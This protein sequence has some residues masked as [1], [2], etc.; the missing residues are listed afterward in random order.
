MATTNYEKKYEKLFS[1][2]PRIDKKLIKQIVDYVKEHP[3]HDEGISVNDILRGVKSKANKVRKYCLDYA[4][5]YKLLEV[6]KK[7]NSHMYP[8]LVTSSGKYK[9][10]KNFNQELEE[11]C[12]LII[13]YFNTHPEKLNLE[14]K[15]KLNKLKIS[16]A[17]EKPNI[18]L[19]ENLIKI[20]WENGIVVSCA[21][22]RRTNYLF[23]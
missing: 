14:L 7:G 19:Q 20:L 22:F 3:K 9:P 2:H 5:P 16:V 15:N 18:G 12:S 6:H 11:S 1:E 10:S 4:I 8:I 13:D 21:T 17:E 23:W